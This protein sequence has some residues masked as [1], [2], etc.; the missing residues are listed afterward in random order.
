MSFLTKVILFCFIVFNFAV[1]DENSTVKDLNNQI[2]KLEKKLE[3]TI[4]FSLKALTGKSLNKNETIEFL[5]KYVVT[6]KD[7]RGDGVVTYLFNDGEYKRYKNFEEISAG[8]WRFT[9]TGKLRVFNEDIKLTWKIK[10]GS[11]NTINIKPKFDPLGKLY[12]FEYK[13]KILFLNELKDYQEKKLNEKKR[14]EQEK[15]DAQRKAEEEKKRLEQEKLD[16]QRKAEEEKKR[17]EQEKLDAQRKAEEEKKRLEQE[18]LDAQRKA[19][20]EKKRLEQEKLDAQRKAEEEKKRL[21]QE[22]LDAQRKAEEEKKRLEQEKLE[23]QRK[24]EEE[25]AKLEK[26]IA[27]QKRKLEEEKAKLEKEIAE[28]KKKLEEEKLYIDLEPKFR[29]KCQKKLLNDLYEI[30]TPEYKICILNKGPEKQKQGQ[31]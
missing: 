12:T 24:A 30:G 11:E 27:E 7:E 19:E 18:K 9:K 31:L 21:E 16:A 4:N 3:D 22:K 8:A 25:K 5:L 20:E 10:I 28:Q 14:L 17:L 13:E 23:A 26:E 15:L 29:K 1:A 2:N 6:L